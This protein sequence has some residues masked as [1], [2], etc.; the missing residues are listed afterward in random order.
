MKLFGK[1]SDQNQVKNDATNQ[2]SVVD[3]GNIVSP[4]NAPTATATNPQSP[5]TQPISGKNSKLKNRKLFM[6]AVV[7]LVAVVLGLSALNRD[8]LADLLDGSGCGQR[9]IDRHNKAI[10]SGNN[11]AKEVKA[12][13]LAVESKKNYTQDITCVYI[14]YQHYSYIQDVGRSRQLLETIKTLEKKGDRIDKKV[15]GIR[16]VEQMEMYIKSLEH[17]RDIGE[18]SD[19]SG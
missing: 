4:N 6:V 2:K 3:V 18:M 19:G 16:T 10:K 1:R 15:V 13:A 9:V 14:V 8:D 5:S 7:V 11:F 12:T 17:N